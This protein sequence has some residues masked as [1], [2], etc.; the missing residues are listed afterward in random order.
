MLE[1]YVITITA[2]SYIVRATSSLEAKCILQEAT[3]LEINV[4]SAQLLQ[5]YMGYSTYPILVLVEEDQN[6]V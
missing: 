2:A 1:F 4:M 5:T 3:N 6:Y